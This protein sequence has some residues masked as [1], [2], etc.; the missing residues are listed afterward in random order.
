[1]TNPFG[2]YSEFFI[3]DENGNYLGA[4]PKDDWWGRFTMTYGFCHGS[5]STWKINRNDGRAK[6]MTGSGTWGFA[7]RRKCCTKIVELVPRKTGTLYPFVSEIS[8]VDNTTWNL[9]LF[10]VKMVENT[11]VFDENSTITWRLSAV[12]I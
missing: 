1:M 2:H 7:A 8:Q 6:I 4:F 3:Q 5:Y 12:G 10:G 11:I 9:R